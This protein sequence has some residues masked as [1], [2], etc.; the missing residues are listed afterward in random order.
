MYSILC[1][2]AYSELRILELEPQPHGVI[3]L[4]FLSDF[5][6]KGVA[7]IEYKTYFVALAL[8]HWPAANNK[9]SAWGRGI[10]PLYIPLYSCITHV[11]GSAGGKSRARICKPF[12]ELRNRFQ[13]WRA[14]THPYLMYRPARLH[15]QAKSIP[16]KRFLGF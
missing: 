4:E 1:R 8:L 15:M 2:L 10:A 14:G 11:E 6:I 9:D 5:Y 16:L 13:A 12:K 3:N 7:V